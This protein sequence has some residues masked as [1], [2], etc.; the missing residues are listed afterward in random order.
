MIAQVLRDTNSEEN[1]AAVRRRVASLTE[2]FPL[3]AW[4]LSAVGV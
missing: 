1:L 3:Y 4:K 2:K